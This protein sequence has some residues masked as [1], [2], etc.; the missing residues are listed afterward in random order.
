MLSASLHTTGEVVAGDRSEPLSTV[1]IPV[2][3]VLDRLRSA[4]NVGNIFRLAEALRIERIITGGYTATPPHEKLAK[5][6]RGCDQMV[7]YQ[8]VDNTAEAIR[9]LKAKNYTIVAVETVPSALSVWEMEYSFPLALVFGNEAEGI[10]SPGLEL[11]D[12][13]VRLPAFGRKNSIN[14]GNAAAVVLYEATRQFWL[15]RN[16]LPGKAF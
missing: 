14:V 6:A 12:A 3:A 8:H 2:V 7:P 4:F 1:T 9:K 16:K 5:T 15:T 11:C 13:T 10:S